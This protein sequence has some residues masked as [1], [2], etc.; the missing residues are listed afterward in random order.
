MKILKQ[1]YQ[2]KKAVNNVDLSI[3]R[4]VELLEKRIINNKE[5]LYELLENLNKLLDNNILE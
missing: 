2:Q 5:V 4:T 1:I 3:V